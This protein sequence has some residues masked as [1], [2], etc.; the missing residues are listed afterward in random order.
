MGSIEG[1]AS[2]INNQKAF[3]ADKETQRG[4]DFSTECRRDR[5]DCQ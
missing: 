3:Y 2:L 1:I 5:S 4:I